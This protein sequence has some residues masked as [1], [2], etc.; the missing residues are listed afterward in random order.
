MGVAEAVVVGWELR[1]GTWNSAAAARARA[2]AFRLRFPGIETLTTAKPTPAVATEA[3]AFHPAA[4]HF[5]KK[6]QLL[7]KAA[8]LTFSNFFS[9]PLFSK[10]PSSNKS[11]FEAHTRREHC[12]FTTTTR[13][14]R[15]SPDTH[16]LFLTEKKLVAETRRH[17]STAADLGRASSQAVSHRPAHHLT[18][19]TSRTAQLAQ[20]SRSR[21]PETTWTKI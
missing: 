9:F 17:R 19:R 2:A 15:K 11:L 6:N 8:A 18:R 1:V 7:K 3:W 16:L 5:P 10:L 20:P 4:P 14:G 13:F 21:E 12:S